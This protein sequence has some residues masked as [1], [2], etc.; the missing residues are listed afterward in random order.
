[1]AEME[2]AKRKVA[3]AALSYIDP[4]QLLGIGTGSTVSCFIEEMVLSKLFPVAAIPT[5][6]K[7]EKL[8]Q[9]AGIKCIRHDQLNQPVPI[10]IDSADVVDYY[11]QAIKGGGGAHRIEKK[12]ASL[13]QTWVCIIDES[14]LIDQ[15][16]EP[17]P[18]PLEIIPT[19]YDQVAAQ[20]KAMDGRLVR[21][22]S[23]KADS[24]NLLADIHGIDLTGDLKKLEIEIERIPGV[25]ACGIFAKRK[26]DIILVGSSDGTV[27]PIEPGR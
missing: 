14:K 26:A 6:L 2:F 13:S 11:G 8:L 23:I 27:I 7:T 24:G 16:R 15:W 12:V 9:E 4:D 5:S 17:F 22:F 10:Y 21:R 20:V 19:E 18:L 3:E 25:A 1:M